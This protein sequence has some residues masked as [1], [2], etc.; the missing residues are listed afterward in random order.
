MK[1]LVG[2]MNAGKV[3]MLI[4]MGSNPVYD[5]PVDFGFADAM[6]RVPLRIQHG[7]YNDETSEHVHWYM[8]GTH[9]LE[10][11]GDVRA[12]DGTVTL[13]QP[14]IAPLYNGKSA[15]RVRVHPGR[16]VG[17]HG[18]RHCSQ[19]WQ[20]QIKGD[21]DNCV[22][23]SA[24]RWIRCQYGAAGQIGFGKGR[25]HS[26][27]RGSQLR[28]M[29]VMFRRDPMVY[30]GSWANNAWLQETPKPIT[31]CLLGQCGPDQS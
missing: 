9:Y 1:D 27:N 14:L 6:D 25:R 17:Y 18:L 31:Q 16:L 24:E 5:A 15:Y 8:N 21:F 30:D 3:D 2:E 12:F 13:I 19:D 26:A 28:P 23:Q 7:L 29:E 11:W 10:Q 22:A 4:V 20:D